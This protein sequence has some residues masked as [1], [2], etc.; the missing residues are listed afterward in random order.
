MGFDDARYTKPMLAEGFIVVELQ[1]AA[2]DEG[3][4][5]NHMFLSKAGELLGH[6]HWHHIQT[7]SSSPKWR[8][9]EGYCCLAYLLEHRLGAG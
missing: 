8:P 3:S 1:G 6:C 2:I 4:C 7:Y 9:A 5:R